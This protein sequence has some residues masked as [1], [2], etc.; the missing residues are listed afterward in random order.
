[1]PGVLIGLREVENVN[2]HS[3]LVVKGL[4]NHR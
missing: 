2:R 3:G 4:A 1:V